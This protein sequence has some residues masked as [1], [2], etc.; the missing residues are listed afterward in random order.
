ME[1]REPESCVALI[2]LVVEDQA[3]AEA[4]N[5]AL[6]AHAPRIVGRMG[7]PYEKRGLSLI[8]V[9]IDA[10]AEEISALAGK[11]GSIPGVSARTVFSRRDGEKQA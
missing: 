1:N 5:A 10:A 11:L 9:A 7:L 3:A 4:I 6:H 2:S 8:S